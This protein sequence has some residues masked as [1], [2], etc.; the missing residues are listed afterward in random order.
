MTAGR[1]RTALLLLAVPLAGGGC[2][3][4]ALLTAPDRRPPGD[5]TPSGSSAIA[6]GFLVAP[7]DVAAGATL[8]PPIE[9]AARDAQGD[10]VPTFTGVV[11]VAL[12]SAPS[13]GTLSGTTARAAVAGV[14]R[15]ADLSVAP[16]GNGYRMVASADGA[17]PVTSPFFDV[18]DVGQPPPPPPQARALAV[19]SGDNQ[20]DTVGATLASPL[21]VRVS[22]ALG[23]PVSGVTV[24]WAVTGGAGSITPSSVTNAAG[25]ASATHVLGPRPGAHTASATVS[26]LSG[27]PAGFTATARHGTPASLEFTVQ[28]NDGTAG[29]ALTPPVQATARD[30]FGNTASGFTGMTTVAIGANPGGGT[31]GGT[32]SRAASGGVATYGDLAISQ[33]GNGY[34]L[35]ASASGLSPATSAPFNVTASPPP[36]PATPTQVARVSGDGQA[37]TVGAALVNPYVVRVTDAAGNPV[38]G[39]SVTWAVTVGGGTIAPSAS[40]TNGVGEASATHTLGLVLGTHTATASTAGLSGSP[41]TFSAT[42]RHGAPAALA[43]RQQPSNVAPLA[44]ITPPVAVALEDRL[45]NAATGFT[46]SLTIAIFSGTGTPGATLSGTLTQ[47]ASGGVATFPDLRVDLVGLGYRLRV[48]SGGLSANSAAFDVIAPAPAPASMERVSGNGQT[49]TAEAALESPYVVRVT[50]TQGTPVPS[51]PVTWVVTS[52]GGLVAPASSATDPAGRASATHTLGSTL[53]SQAA[54]AS[55]AG[56]SGSPVTFTSTAT[57]GAP[58]GLVF[59]RQP[60]SVAPLVAIT[61]PVQVAM[62]DRLGNT[63]TGYAGSVAIGLTPGTGTPGATLAGT[64][65]RALVD[66]IATFPDLSIALIGVGY[67]LRVTAQ[68]LTQDSAPFDVFLP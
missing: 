28:P 4:D 49:D 66:G 51:V 2:K 21:I 63:A 7:S 48:A 3:L 41:V 42:A 60:S 34:T 32:T 62:I 31:L 14:A 40:T 15:F 5:S 56:L 43:Y 17:A 57:H 35:T 68:G 58:A 9:V 37:D 16:A 30:G 67:R 59:R 22:D 20:S 12:A 47:P 23:L 13:G 55:V 18:E 8:S 50:D 29:S 1:F 54:T 11:T 38:S 10:V 65:T 36:P 52:G 25:R 64:L 44:V 24:S 46:G 61:P 45:G 39:V 53:G 19:V 26:G 6:L 27:S 33:G